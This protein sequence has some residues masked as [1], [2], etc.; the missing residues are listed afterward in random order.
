[1]QG[2]ILGKLGPN[3]PILRDYLEKRRIVLTLL[4]RLERHR[5]GVSFL[6]FYVHESFPSPCVCVSVLMFFVW[7]QGRNCIPTGRD[8]DGKYL[9]MNEK[10]L[11]DRYAKFQNDWPIFGVTLMCD[12]WIGST[13]MSVINFFIYCN[14]VTWFHKSIDVTRKSQ[15]SDYLKTVTPKPVLIYNQTLR[16]FWEVIK[17][18]AYF[19]QEIR[20]VVKEIGAEHI[21]R[22]VNNSSNHKRACKKAA[23]TIARCL[24]SCR[25]PR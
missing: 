1:M 16:M 6:S 3:S 21:V 12:S 25:I 7:L 5:S 2:N 17:C 22:I 18:C 14:G 9:D 8:I 20:K 24:R 11:K 15:N 13:R 19:L 10:D 23:S 4:V